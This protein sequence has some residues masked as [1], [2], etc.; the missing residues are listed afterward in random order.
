MSSRKP[1]P[2]LP[3]FEEAAALVA[4]HA[5][6]LGRIRPAVER[7]K[8]GQALGRVLAEPIRADSDQPPFARSTRDGFACRATEASAHTQLAIAGMTR[9][10]ETPAGQLPRG[11]AWEIMTG[12]P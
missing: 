11:A 3:T 9:A 10:G 12:A 5:A 6:K 2:N 8:L 4:A 1:S 7:V